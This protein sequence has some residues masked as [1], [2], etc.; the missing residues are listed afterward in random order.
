MKKV[1]LY[2]YPLEEYNR[3]FLLPR[4]YCEEVHKEYPLDVLNECL[5]T[6]YRDK[7]YEVVIAMY[8]DKQM[9][10]LDE[11]SYDRVILTDVTFKEASGYNSDGSEKRPEDIKYPSEAYLI[12]QLGDVDELMVG[13]F[14][15]NDCVKRVTNKAL[16]MGIDALVDIELTDI[17]Y[18]VYYQDYFVKSDYSKEKFREYCITSETKYGCPLELAERM[19]NRNYSDQAFGFGERKVNKL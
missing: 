18:A 11:N 4:D 5:L 19:F 7:G 8:P 15:M 3:I 1:F 12:N 13:G 16:E 17:F 10:G 9:F 2:L 6:R 14:H